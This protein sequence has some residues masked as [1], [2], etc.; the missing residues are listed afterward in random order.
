LDGD[1]R[2]LDSGGRDVTAQFLRGAEEC[3]AAA[4]LFGVAGA[5][6]KARSPSCALGESYD[7]TFSGRLVRGSGVTAALLS[8]HGLPILSEDDL[9][10]GRDFD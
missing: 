6:L 9:A 3:L 2:V 4:R 1:A 7:G 10:A 8:R 5:V